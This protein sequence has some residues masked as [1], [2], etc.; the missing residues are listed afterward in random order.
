[1]EGCHFATKMLK[2]VNYVFVVYQ[3]DYAYAITF[4][5]VIAREKLKLMGKSDDN[6]DLSG[7]TDWRETCS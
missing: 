1:M 3:H 6:G 4:Q 7:N 2:A 5:V